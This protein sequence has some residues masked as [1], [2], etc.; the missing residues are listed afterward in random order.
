MPQIA[1]AA[2]FPFLLPSYRSLKADNFHLLKIILLSSSPLFSLGKK[3]CFPVGPMAVN[4]NLCYSMLSCISP[5]SSCLRPVLQMLGGILCSRNE[6]KEENSPCTGVWTLT[7]RLGQGDSPTSLC[8]WNQ[9]VAR[10]VGIPA[11]HSGSP[12]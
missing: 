12:R 11:W 8:A 1:P 5:G 10:K 9:E 2:T 6:F 4:S 3:P 7:G